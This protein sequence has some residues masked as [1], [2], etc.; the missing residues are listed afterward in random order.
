MNFI[1]GCWDMQD[2]FNISAADAAAAQDAAARYLT[3]WQIRFV[4]RDG[5]VIVP[6]NLHLGMLD[7]VALP[8]LSAV[9]VWGNFS[10]NSNRL[11]TLKGAPWRVDGDFLCG[12]NNLTTLDGAPRSVGGPSIAAATGCFP[13][14]RALF[15]GGE[16]CCINNEG[17]KHLEH[18]PAAFSQLHSD[19]GRFWC[20]EEV[21]ES[22]RWSPETRLRLLAEAVT[23][24]TVLQQP[25]RKSKPL[26]FRR[27]A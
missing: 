6:K 17:L 10:C 16:F 9:E 24:H 4:R 11:S 5:R 21:P 25:V 13:K 8:D 18:A 19:F 20:P 14:R 7:I 27:R 1:H 15:G 12:A 26:R 2:A 23:E 22:L 3:T